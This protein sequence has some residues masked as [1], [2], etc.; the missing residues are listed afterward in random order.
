M[1]LYF[2]VHGKMKHITKQKLIYKKE[3][4]RTKVEKIVR[5]VAFYGLVVYVAVL[6]FMLVDAN[7]DLTN[8]QVDMVN[9]SIMTH[10]QLN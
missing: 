1:Y 10:S 8:A 3:A 7:I 4:D 6:G 2:K 5:D 9:N